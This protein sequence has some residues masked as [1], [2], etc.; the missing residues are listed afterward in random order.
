MSDRTTSRTC[1]FLMSY[2]ISLKGCG[3]VKVFRSHGI[4]SRDIKYQESGRLVTSPNFNPCMHALVTYIKGSLQAKAMD[5]CSEWMDHTDFSFW[6][7]D[8]WPRQARPKLGLC[9]LW[10]IHSAF[11]KITKLN[12]EQYFSIGKYHTVWPSLEIVD[13][14]HTLSWTQS[15][16]MISRKK[17]TKNQLYIYNKYKSLRKVYFLAW[18]CS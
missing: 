7:G 17:G 11:R 3:G 5:L 9:R 16:L 10:S 6:F 1:I 13:S 15:Q 4:K 12:H 8:L 2:K 14:I 18:F